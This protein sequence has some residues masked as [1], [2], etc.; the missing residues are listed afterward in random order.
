MSPPLLCVVFK[1]N[2]EKFL[3]SSAN[4]VCII[5]ILRLHSLYD[6]SRSSDLTWDNAHSA[7][8]SCV[9]INVG[10]SCASLPTLKACISRFFPRVFHTATHS[11]PGGIVHGASF[12]HQRRPSNH[13]T[14]THLPSGNDHKHMSRFTIG[15][16]A[17]KG[18][19]D[20]KGGYVHSQISSQNGRCIHLENLGDGAHTP[21]LSDHGI[22]VVTVV[23]QEVHES[24]GA[25]DRKSE[26]GSEK[27]LFPTEGRGV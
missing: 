22:N 4:S 1:E 11:A 25:R 3:T 26:S 19:Q 17:T 21:P 16:S 8:W 24:E 12:P 9:E 6:A 27:A 13:E 20:R 23:K 14:W 5:S 7:T 15:G 2:Q 10:I 18:F